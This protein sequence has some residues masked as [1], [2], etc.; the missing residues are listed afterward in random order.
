MRRQLGALYRIPWH[1]GLQR[2]QADQAA[3][4]A[5]QA[6]GILRPLLDAEPNDALCRS[7]LADSYRGLGLAAHREGKQAEARK[8]FEQ[9]L[10]VLRQAP[11]AASPAPD[12]PGQEELL[13]VLECNRACLADRATDMTAAADRL[14]ALSRTGSRRASLYAAC[15]YAGAGKALLAGRQPKDLS[16][17][18]RTAAEGHAARSLQFLKAAGDQGLLN[19]EFLQNLPALAGLRDREDFRTLLKEL[20][21]KARATSP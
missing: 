9:G 15:G 4:A 20:G 3:S 7:Y 8:A 14:A 10:A 21:K 2:G 12:A 1:V 16:Q 18:E 6:I 13:A 11:K 5:R 17:A 19:V